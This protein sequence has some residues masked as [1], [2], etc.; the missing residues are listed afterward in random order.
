MILK[1]NFSIN[2]LDFYTLPHNIRA[3][4]TIHKD[5]DPN[6]IEYFVVIRRSVCPS[7]P[8]TTFIADGVSVRYSRSLWKLATSEH[9]GLQTV[10]FPPKIVRERDFSYEHSVHSRLFRSF[11]VPIGSPKATGGH[12]PSPC[13]SL[14]III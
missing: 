6:G 12:I 10:L 7:T 3:S 1:V 2:S 8:V 4:R 13:T 14:N 11:Q 5:Q 9:R